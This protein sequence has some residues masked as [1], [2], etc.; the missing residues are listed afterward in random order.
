LGALKV[1]SE[2]LLFF[3]AFFAADL[4]RSQSLE[5]HHAITPP[6]S[7]TAPGHAGCG[8]KPIH[9]TPAKALKIEINERSRR[10]A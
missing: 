1:S 8:L 10:R 7:N 9:I 2:I 3:Y 5:D 6:T 4:F